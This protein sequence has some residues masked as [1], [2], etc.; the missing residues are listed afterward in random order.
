MRSGR[1][2]FRSAKLPGADEN[3]DAAGDSLCMYDQFSGILAYMLEL[4]DSRA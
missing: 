2:P 1:A 4:A 3:V